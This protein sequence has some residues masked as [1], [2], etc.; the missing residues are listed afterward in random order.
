MSDRNVNDPLVSVLDAIVQQAP[1]GIITIDQQGS[2]QIANQ[3]L[4]NQLAIEQSLPEVK[5][6]QVLDLVQK[7]V[8]LRQKLRSCLKR[9]RFKFNIKKQVFGSSIYAIRGRKVLD[10]MLITIEDMTE[11]HRSQE[12]AL[13]ALSEGQEQERRRIARDLHDDIGPVLSAIRILVEDMHEQIGEEGLRN[14]PGS[15]QTLLL[16]D[17]AASDIRQLSHD[18]MPKVLEDFGLERALEQYCQRLRGKGK[19]DV[20]FLSTISTEIDHEVALGV[21]RMAQELMRNSFKHA[22]AKTMHVQLIGHADTLVL[23][24][25]DDG[26]GF[27]LQAMRE[28]D[29]GIGLENVRYRAASLGG[30]FELDAKPGQGVWCLIEV[31]YKLNEA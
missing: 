18:L 27:D 14:L 17:Q 28:K 10:S 31:P 3:T 11:H 26:Q 29:G 25:E 12:R 7:P 5:G 4:L 8:E 2:I 19:L 22:Q 16:L 6:K 9:R 23:Q 30:N 20:V 21:Y 1:Y 24:V 13:L 15:D